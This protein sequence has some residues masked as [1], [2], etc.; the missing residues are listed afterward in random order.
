MAIRPSGRRARPLARLRVGLVVVEKR[1]T[2]L[3]A[4]IV[5]RMKSASVAPEAPMN[6]VPS[7]STMIGPVRLAPGTEVVV[8]VPVARSIR[9]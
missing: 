1:A 2:K 9:P 6:T 8:W 4:P 7:R 3:F 5:A